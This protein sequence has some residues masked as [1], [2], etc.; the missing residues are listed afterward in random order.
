VAQQ[1]RVVHD[2]E[3]EDVVDIGEG[4]EGLVEQER[5][6]PGAARQPIGLRY[7]GASEPSAV[8]GRRRS[9]SRS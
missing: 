1:D 7:T 5:I 9:Q 4:I 3:V 2:A 8:S 6:E